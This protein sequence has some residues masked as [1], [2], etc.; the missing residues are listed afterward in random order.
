[1]NTGPL[2][3][4][5]AIIETVISNQNTG[6]TY[7]DIV[8]RTGLPKSSVHRVLKELTQMGYLTFSRETKKYRGSMRL[9]AI[10]AEVMANFDVR[11]HVHPYLLDLHRET[12]HTSNMGIRNGTV[13]VFIDK[14][15][16][17]DYGIKLFSEV[18]KTFPL[19]CTGLGKVL[20]AYAPQDNTEA[21][22]DGPLE[23]VTDNTITDPD[24][25]LAELKEVRSRGYA[26]DY[27]EITRGIMCV[28]APVYGVR[29]DV[30]CAIS[31]TFPS[32]IYNDR[33][34]EPEIEAV[35]K[36]AAALSGVFKKQLES[37]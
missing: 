6:M 18:G 28:A 2:A 36:Y 21:V 26:L 19:H 31:V 12:E 29:G 33:G 14:I 1:M 27:E 20:L 8:G 30:V 22:L 35:R 5:F 32:Y 11:D 17:Q 25:L 34:I 13:G 4:I 23:A 15:E 10:G 7:T 24:K 37:P 3:K 16:S 9:A